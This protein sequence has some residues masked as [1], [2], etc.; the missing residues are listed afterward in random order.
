LGQ[1]ES[2]DE[3]AAEEFEQHVGGEVLPEESALEAARKHRSHGCGDEAFDL[4]RVALGASGLPQNTGFEIAFL[5]SAAGAIVAAMSVLLIPDR[6]RQLAVDVR[7]QAALS[8]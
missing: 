3:G 5:I 6:G 4:A 8:A 7:A 1:L 2:G